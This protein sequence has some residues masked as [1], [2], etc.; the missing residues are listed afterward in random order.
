MSTTDSTF[1]EVIDSLNGFDE[2][3][4]QSAAG[5]SLDALL[6]KARLHAVRTVVAIHIM[7]TSEPRMKYAAAYRQAMEMSMKA[8]QEY[9]AEPPRDPDPSNPDSEVG[10]GS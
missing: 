3:A 7:R 8:V 4:I 10:K 9:F 1:D 6:E 5:V 2:L